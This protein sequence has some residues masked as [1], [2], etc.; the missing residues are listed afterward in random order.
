MGL[1]VVLGLR[2]YLEGWH[3]VGEQWVVTA[4]QPL[5]SAA[6]PYQEGPSLVPAQVPLPLPQALLLLVFPPPVLRHSF[7]QTKH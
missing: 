2:T 4:I 3:G 7:L 1:E 5:I 6:H